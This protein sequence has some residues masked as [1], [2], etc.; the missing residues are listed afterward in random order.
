MKD[1][2]VKSAEAVGATGSGAVSAAVTGRGLVGR[3][4]GRCAGLSPFDG[5]RWLLVIA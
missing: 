1:L 2:I 4:H 3:L 5:A